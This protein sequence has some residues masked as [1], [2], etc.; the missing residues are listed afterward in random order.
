MPAVKKV[1]RVDITTGKKEELPA[2]EEP[3]QVIPAYQELEDE[4]ADFKSF[5]LDEKV[6][7]EKLSKYL[8]DDTDIEGKSFVDNGEKMIF[9]LVS[10]MAEYP[11]FRAFRLERFPKKWLHYAM[12]E[13]G[14]GRQGVL[15]VLKGN[16]QIGAPK[17][18][19]LPTVGRR[20]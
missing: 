7:T 18:D 8:V 2:M 1:K 5:S 14:R 6:E 12:G 11:R 10:I 9:T 20:V 4:F 15:D 16:V 17:D 19:G 3:L 13:K